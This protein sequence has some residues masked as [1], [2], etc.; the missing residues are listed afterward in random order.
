MVMT[1]FTLKPGQVVWHNKQ[2]GKIA[3]PGKPRMP[4]R[5][6]VKPLNIDKP[7]WRIW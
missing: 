6:R 5:V 2:D 4:K 7:W 1:N 3:I